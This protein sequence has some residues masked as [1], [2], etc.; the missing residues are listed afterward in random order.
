MKYLLNILVLILLSACQNNRQQRVDYADFIAEHQLQ[1]LNRVQQFNFLGWQPLNDRYL[2]L[3]GN[4][5]KSFLIQ[6]MSPCNEL[7]YA[8][9]IHLKQR[10]GTILSSKFDSVIVPGQLNQECRI[11]AIYPL[12]QIQQ[13]AL[14]DYSGHQR[15]FKGQILNKSTP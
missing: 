7:P 10:S 1:N 4:Q 2:I 5:R 13:Q 12:D 11:N 8:V 9:N 14:L 3:R 15:Q 6:L